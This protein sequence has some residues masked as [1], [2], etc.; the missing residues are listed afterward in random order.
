[1]NKKIKTTIT[2]LLVTLTMIFVSL[3]SVIDAKAAT[4]NY[5][6]TSIESRTVELVDGVT[7]LTVGGNSYQLTL[8][9]TAADAAADQYG[10]CWM[11]YKNGAIYF[12][13][14]EIEGTSLVKHRLYDS[15]GAAVYATEL[16][17]K[18]TNPIVATHYRDKNGVEK[19]LPTLDELKVMLGITQ[20]PSTEQPT[21]QEPSTEQPTTQQP[22]NQEEETT[23][24]T[25]VTDTTINSESQINFDYYWKQFQEGKI[26][27]DQFST[28]VGL[29]N[30]KTNKEYEETSTTYYV[31]NPDGTIAYTTTVTTGNK[32]E[33]GTGNSN[34]TNTNTGTSKV[35]T[36][37]TTKGNAS[38]T[39][40]TTT[41]ATSTTKISSSVSKNTATVKTKVVKVGYDHVKVSGKKVAW[42]TKKGKTKSICFLR[43]NG[44]FKFN[45]IKGK[46]IR[47]VGYIKKNQLLVIRLKNNDWYIIDIKTNKSQK[48][49]GKIIRMCRFDKTNFLKAVVMKNGKKK[50]VVN[51]KINKKKAKYRKSFK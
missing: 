42:I 22:S 33:T 14:Y 17:F 31:Y 28:I 10:T 45:V 21:P 11:L 49:K 26:T 27:W 34:T 3:T 25:I 44:N 29:Y 47:S 6:F 23:T 30:W 1:M 20:E 24:S 19:A 41:K 5:T 39:V 37:T 46:K 35:E 36:T 2:A 12:A 32:T 51:L 38:G 43:K 8:R 7:T 50:S 18:G 4:Y 13:S 16:L 48:M 15:T 9:L 40:K